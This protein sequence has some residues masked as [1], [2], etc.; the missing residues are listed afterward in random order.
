VRLIHPT[1]CPRDPFAKRQS[2]LKARSVHINYRGDDSHPNEHLNFSMLPSFCHTFHLIRGRTQ[3]RCVRIAPPKSRI[4]RSLAP[5]R[6]LARSSRRGYR[7]LTL[8]LLVVD[9][10]GDARQEFDGA[11]TLTTAFRRFSLCSRGDRKRET[12]RQTERD[13]E[14]KTVRR[15]APQPR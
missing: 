5:E 4:D 11:L 12:E 8:P 7:G 13:R 14:R 15:R 10:R 2:R 1:L 6:E 3:A 9:A